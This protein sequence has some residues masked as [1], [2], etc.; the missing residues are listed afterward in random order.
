MN[1]ISEWYWKKVKEKRELK[2]KKKKKNLGKIVYKQKIRKNPDNA[3]KRKREERSKNEEV[4]ANEKQNL[5]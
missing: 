4:F 5:S 1:D 3:I 2:A